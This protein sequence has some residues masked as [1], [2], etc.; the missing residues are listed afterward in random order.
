[1][2]NKNLIVIANVIIWFKNPVPGYDAFLEENL[3]DISGNL[4]LCPLL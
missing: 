2:R 1:M 3:L 4:A